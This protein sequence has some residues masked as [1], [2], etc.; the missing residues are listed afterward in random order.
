MAIWLTKDSRVI[1][2]GVTG[3]E[4][5]KHTRRML[6]AGTNIVGGT[7]PRKAG[8]QV[9][10]DGTAVPVFGG[11]TARDAVAN[12][13]LQA[14]TLLGERGETVDKPLV[15]RLDGNNA[16]EGRRIL[17]SANNPLVERVDTM[18]GAARRAAELARA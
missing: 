4:G 17:D 6:R 8:Q 18:D 12:G 14:F 10:F 9:D 13:I 11:I 16:D 2:Q 3:S 1:V 5:S 15:V 7:N